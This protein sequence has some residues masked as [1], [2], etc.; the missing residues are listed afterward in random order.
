MEKIYVNGHRLTVA[1]FEALLPGL[2]VGG[3]LDLYGTKIT[4]LP[5]GLTV[6]GDLVLCGTG[7]PEPPASVKIGGK[8]YR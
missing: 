4:S 7:V 5:E 1:E 2:T 3:S 8:I 6:G